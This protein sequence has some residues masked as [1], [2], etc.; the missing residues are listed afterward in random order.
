M[1]IKQKVVCFIK[2][3]L[4]KFLLI[5][6]LT[7]SVAVPVSAAGNDPEITPMCSF[8]GNLCSLIK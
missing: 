3:K 4:S 5:S 1:N 8:L 2:K 6:L 7:F